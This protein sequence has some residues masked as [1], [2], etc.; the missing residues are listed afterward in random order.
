MAYWFGGKAFR[1]LVVGL[2]SVLIVFGIVM[3]IWL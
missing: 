3:M 2:F 1:N